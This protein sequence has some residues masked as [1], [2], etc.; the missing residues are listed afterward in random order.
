MEYELCLEQKSLHK[1]QVEARILNAAQA[2]AIDKQQTVLAEMERCRAQLH[3]L[4]DDRLDAFVL[5]IICGGLSEYIQDGTVRAVPLV[6]APARC[7][8]MKP[9]AVVLPD[10]SIAETT[11]WKKA[12][13]MI[14]R[15]CDA[16]P[17]CH[18]Q[19]M[20]M[21]GRVYGNF[22]SLLAETPNCMDAP[23]KITED[24]YLESKF[25]TK[26]MLENLTKKIL[27]RVG[28]DCGRIAVLYRSPQQKAGLING[29]IDPEISA[30]TEMIM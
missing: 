26:A 29:K 3:Q 21:R 7:K 2:E 16:N 4:I 30:P 24:L 11:T 15:D 14:L 23:L 12:A 13:T 8:G 28:Y 22:R 17:G 5:Q 25:D 9:V 1:E 19:L 18:E 6:S 10:G 27:C 20:E